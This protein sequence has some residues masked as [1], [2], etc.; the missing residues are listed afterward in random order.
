MLQYNCQ[1]ERQKQQKRKEEKKMRKE[2]MVTR[3]ITKVTFKVMVVNTSNGNSVETVEVVTGEPTVDGDK[4][5][6]F[7]STKLEKGLLFV[8]IVGK[9]TV[10]E[11]YGMTES[12]FMKYAI[13]LPDRK[14]NA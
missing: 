9:E 6:K 2:K 8:K 14:V 13:R 11:L 12:E 3:T 1:K 5:D 10:D 7:V 4:L